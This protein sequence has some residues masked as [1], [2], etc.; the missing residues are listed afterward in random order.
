MLNMARLNAMEEIFD[1]V[2]ILEKPALFTCCRIERSTI[3]KGYEM[4]EVRHDDDCRGDAVQI[5]RGIM[6]NHW[7]TLITREEIELPEDGRLNIDSDDL[8][9]GCGDCSTMKEFMEKYP[10]KV[11]PSRNRGR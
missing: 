3:P 5:A 11:P 9:Y 10:Q 8:N 6:V 1:E 7:G 4:Y 2:T